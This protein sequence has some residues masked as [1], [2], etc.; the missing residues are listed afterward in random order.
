[1]TTTGRHSWQQSAKSVYRH[2]TGP[3]GCIRLRG[4]RL[5]LCRFANMP[6]LR[7]IHRTLTPGGVLGLIW[8]IEDCTGSEL[9][10]RPN[11]DRR[12]R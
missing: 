4:S 12:C 11:A 5:T 10:R 3:D 9:I 1:M 8:N 2:F 6:A 7:E